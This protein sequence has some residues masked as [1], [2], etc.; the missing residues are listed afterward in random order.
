MHGRHLTRKGAAWVFQMRLPGNAFSLRQSPIRI[1]LGTIPKRVA[2]RAARMLAMAACI[3]LERARLQLMTD[4]TTTTTTGQPDIRRDVT[5]RLKINWDAMMP[6]LCGLDDVDKCQPS[7]PSLAPRMV[8]AGFDGLAA[9][10]CDIAAGGALARTQRA[11]I[12][13]YFRRVIT[14]EATGRAHLGEAPLPAAPVSPLPAAPVSPGL[15]EV[16][17]MVSAMRAEM[18]AEIQAGHEAIRKQLATIAKPE[19]PLFSAAADAYHDTLREANGPGYDELKY[20]RHRKAVFLQI[21]GDKP[22]GLYTKKDLQT[23][24]NEVRFLPPNISKSADFDI[25]DIKRHIAEA[26]EKGAPG[27]SE[28]TLVN[29]YLSRVKT[30]IRNGCAE[31]GIPFQLDNVRIIVPKGV[32]KGKRRLTPDYDALNKVFRA[33][34]ATG[35]LAETMLPLLGFLTGR[36]LGLLT[37]LCREDLRRY[38]G[39]WIVPPRDITKVEDRYIMVPFKTNESLTYFVLHDVLAELGFM[40]WARRGTGFIFRSLHEAKD[41]ADTASKRMARLFREAGVD[42]EH[43]K[44]FHGLRHARISLNRQLKLDPRVCRLQV[45]HELEGVHDQYGSDQ[46]MTHDEIADVASAKLPLE[47]DLSIFKGLDFEA[48]AAARPRP[49]RPRKGRD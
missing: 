31:A 41:P 3:H 16:R 4:T 42:P 48:L 30:I 20:L 2:Q 19:G 22:V 23:F 5:A 43:F 45:G 39:C 8:E 9:L 49:G 38:H 29:T 47:I 17:D 46:G 36:R 37:F 14:D 18:R 24:V 32:P 28:S 33:G 1:T 11:P 13:D 10:A 12:L 34:V 21:C 25:A 15:G 27:L 7:D 6:L 35:M 40:D 26:K 44:M